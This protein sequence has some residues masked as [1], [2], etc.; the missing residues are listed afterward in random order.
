MP[1]RLKRTA[2]YDRRPLSAGWQLCSTP[3]GTCDRPDALGRADLNWLPACAPST[4]A[5]CLL[6]AGAWSRDPGQ[7]RI[8]AVDWWYRTAF[9]RPVPPGG[10]WILG[11]DGLASHAEVWLN[12]TPL[13][14]SDNMFLA[15]ECPLD[16]LLADH[17]ELVIR[18][19]SL[20]EI[21]KEKRPRPRW[22]VPMLAAQQLR[23]HRT[24]LLGRTPGW[25]PPAPPVGPWRPVW[26]EA[27]MHVALKDL[28]LRTGVEENYGWV[29]VRCA[30]QGIDGAAPAS[31]ELRVSRNGHAWALK[32][33]ARSGGTDAGVTV[34]SGRLTVPRVQ[35]WWPHTHGEPALYEARLA[36]RLPGSSDEIVAELGRVGFRT[37]ALEVRDGDFAVTV[38][39]VAVFCRGACWTPTDPV[40]FATE[41]QVLR[42]SFAQLRAAGMNMLRVGGMMVY[43]SD[44][45]LD[46]CDEE[47]ILLWQDFMFAN[48]DYPY[49]DAAFAASVD[50]EARQQLARLG[51]RPALAVLCGNSE[52]EQQPAMSA[53]PRERWTA[54]L[55]HEV[56]PRLVRELSPD[57]PYWPSSA[58]GGA[59]PHQASSGSSSYYGVGA[60]LRPLEDARRAQLRFASECLGFANVPDEDALQS[61]PG[62]WRS[63]TPRDLG[64]A[65]DFDDV[66]DHYLGRLFR[67]DPD[68]LRSADP[69]RYL[70]M[71]RVASGEVMA[72]AFAEW[73][74]QRSSCRGALV[75]FWRDLWASAGWGV[76]DARGK[77]KA[78]YRYLARAL[79]PVAIFMSDEG[80]NGLTLHVANERAETLKGRIE[81]TLYRRGEIQV[82]HATLEVE[83]APRTTLEL[84]ATDFFDG[85]YDLNYA[86]RFGPPSHDLV[87]ARLLGA[88]GA[89]LSE[90]CF[91]PLGLPNS[92]EA[93]VG[94]TAIATTRAGGEFDLKVTTRRFA[95][96]VCI[97]AAGF[98]AGD[99]YFH[100][101]PGAT[102]V[103]VLRP[104]REPTAQ[105]GSTTG[106]GTPRGFV[107]ALNST[108]AAVIEVS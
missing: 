16:R 49:E 41:P 29:E 22:R 19:R 38:N 17:N 80:G 18:F 40:G 7:P 30:A 100:L 46:L 107:R 104:T 93:D 65:W 106:P 105:T 2:G 51:A 92:T 4:V 84:A 45:F 35:R 23:W 31:A 99:D 36:L 56:L 47:G 14:T 25:S 82:E 77:P 97:D 69:Q 108:A 53:A 95:Q 89:C 37:L 71:S 15:H 75:W 79:Q 32:L 98:V 101:A 10:R 67:I 54:P 83:A 8:D 5:Q 88:D 21:L 12:G 24:T 73:R 39:G 61:I 63:R 44:E 28:L 64:A 9:P 3:A 33:T 6:A 66:R 94:L 20:D 60:Y 50:Q 55:F 1:S 90:S 85:W 102:R 62:S 48:M 76:I 91:F 52:G 57:T 27:R 59:F 96:S 78:A 72:S 58:H 11:F 70:A 68:T 43:E 87:V 86:Y 13:L 74:R 34:F 26:L 103:I 42:E 81:L